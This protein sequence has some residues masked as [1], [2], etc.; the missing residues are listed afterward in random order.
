MDRRGPEFKYQAAEPRSGTPEH[1]RQWVAFY[2]ELTELE[3]NVLAHMKE[4]A[5]GRPSEIQEALRRSN[6][7][8][9]ERFI[10]ELRQVQGR[11]AQVARHGHLTDTAAE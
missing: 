3:L 9:L 11:W 1:A 7:E 4:L 8:P 5:S 2:S 6:I 10:E